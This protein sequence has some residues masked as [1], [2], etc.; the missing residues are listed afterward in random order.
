MSHHTARADL[1]TIQTLWPELTAEPRRRRPRTTRPITPE[2]AAARAALARAELADVAA[3]HVG[4]GASPAAADIPILDTRAD[5]KRAIL[6][7]ADQVASDTQPPPHPDDDS[8]WHYTRRRDLDWA[9][10]WLGWQLDTAPPRAADHIASTA[11]TIAQQ[12]QAAIDG[13]SERPAGTCRC[14]VRLTVAD[15]D[16][17]IVCTGCRT[18]YG[19]CD[20]IHLRHRI[21]S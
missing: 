19:R 1:R 20:W 6:D 2:R 9:C 16:D 15:W 8:A 14:G 18:A 21:A 12:L 13:Q 4:R 3:G 5:I 17:L 10:S 11:R 7:L